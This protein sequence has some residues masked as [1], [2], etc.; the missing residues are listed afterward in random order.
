MLQRVNK[1]FHNVSVA[2]VCVYIFNKQ[3]YKEKFYT[4]ARDWNKHS[5]FY[6]LREKFDFLGSIR[7]EAGEAAAPLYLGIYIVELVIYYSHERCS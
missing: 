1:F 6:L 2:F 4:V 3:Q 5:N 7:G